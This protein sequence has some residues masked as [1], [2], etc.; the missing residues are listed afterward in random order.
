MP[1]V[2]IHCCGVCNS[3][4]R[5]NYVELK[6]SM[7]LLYDGQKQ[8]CRAS[9]PSQ[10]STVLNKKWPKTCWCKKKDGCNISC[11]KSNGENI[12]DKN[13]WIITFYCRAELQHPC[14]RHSTSTP[15][16]FP[17]CLGDNHCILGCSSNMLI[18]S[19]INI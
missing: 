4:N 5:Q 16:M 7:Q 11:E 15:T 3:K 9:W 14:R 17:M 19:N 2:M 13:K 6:A 18:L 1:F 8:K 12:F 10:W